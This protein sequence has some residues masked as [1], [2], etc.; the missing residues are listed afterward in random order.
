MAADIFAKFK[1]D[2]EVKFTQEYGSN[3]QVDDGHHRQD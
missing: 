1:K 2:M 3:Q